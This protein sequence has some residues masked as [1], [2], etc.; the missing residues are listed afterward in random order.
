M[1]TPSHKKK[2]KTNPMAGGLASLLGSSAPTYQKTPTVQNGDCFFDAVL[3][4]MDRSNGDF[5]MKKRAEKA[6]ERRLAMAFDLTLATYVELFG[7]DVSC[8]NTVHA[9]ESFQAELSK[10]GD[11][12]DQDDLSEFV[13]QK[14][15]QLT[16][17]LLDI[18]IIVLRSKKGELVTQQDPS[19]SMMHITQ[20]PFDLTR[21]TVVL[22]NIGDRHY[23]P[24]VTVSDQNGL[25]SPTSP[26][27]ERLR[28]LYF[29]KNTERC[30][31]CLENYGKL[32]C[33]WH[34]AHAIHSN[35][36]LKSLQDQE[37]QCGACPE[38]KAAPSHPI[39]VKIFMD[40]LSY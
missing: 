20:S 24:L 25:H 18:N 40:N 12:Y 23:E 9:F 13:G 28:E 35:S 17:K 21:D 14:C 30:L 34:C 5:N 29:Q 10:I 37:I 39:A 3:T 32:Q 27:V 33:L 19:D 4:A 2:L 11:E 26:I 16:M 22:V 8:E 38:C 1:T 15:W 6:V 7:G 36:C 31:V